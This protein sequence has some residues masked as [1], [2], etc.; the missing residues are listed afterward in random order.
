MKQ[1]DNEEKSIAANIAKEDP[2]PIVEEYDLE[3]KKEEEYETDNQG[4]DDFMSFIKQS[5]ANKA[6]DP[7]YDRYSVAITPSQLPGAQPKKAT[8]DE[9]IFGF[10]QGATTGLD[11]LEQL[12]GEPSKSFSVPQYKAP[13]ESYKQFPSLRTYQPPSSYG[14]LKGHVCAKTTSNNPFDVFESKYAGAP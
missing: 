11:E 5:A 14:Q 3:E 6:A 4:L 10:A 13:Y 7:K 8:E 9:E 12:F 1:E 2:T